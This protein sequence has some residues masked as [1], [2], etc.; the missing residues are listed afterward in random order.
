MTL[1]QM[2][3]ETR[4]FLESHGVGEASLESELFVMKATGLDRPHLYS[5]PDRLVTLEERQTLVRDLARRANGEPWPYICGYR[6]F[7]GL[8]IKVS[9]RV[10]IPR[11][12]TEL[13]VDL[14]L[15]QA[16]TFPADRPLRI[17]DVC[18]GS[19]AIAVALAVHLPQAV[20]YA[21]D[22]T[23]ESFEIA[24]L[25]CETF[26]VGDRVHVLEGSLLEPVS[27]TFDIVVSN[28]PYVPRSDFPYLSREVRTETLVALDGGEDGLAVIRS[29]LP[30]A[31]SKLRRPGSL[32]VEIAPEQGEEVCAL[33]RSLAPQGDFTLHKDLAGRN[34]AML[35]RLP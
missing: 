27:G 10:F 11:P 7:Y 2:L 17:A 29:L 18:T 25:N 24:K 20:V 15:E 5:S 26:Q 21:T 22:V 28:P 3:Q 23:T 8:K 16:R 34:R 12:E 32:I 6:E 33:A 9:P 31:I 4:L 19:G 14:A 13:L 35:A 30:Q 1:G